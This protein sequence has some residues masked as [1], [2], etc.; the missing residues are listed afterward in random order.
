MPQY[1]FMIADGSTMYF[2][3]VE[4]PIE[5]EDSGLEDLGGR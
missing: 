3:K 5:R 4:G 2:E 1:L